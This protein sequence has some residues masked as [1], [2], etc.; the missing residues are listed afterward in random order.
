MSHENVEVS[1]RAFEDAWNNG[2]VDVLEE[3][4][5]DGFVDHDPLMGDQDAE[6]IKRTVAM[7]REAFPDLTMTIDDIFAAD[8]DK[9]V[10]R[11]TA[12]GTFQNEIMG[13]Q[14]NNNRATVSG[15]A[16]DRFEDGR[17][18][19]TWGQWNTLKFMQSIGAIPTEASAAV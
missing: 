6:G 18:A 2:N 13:I 1:R 5:A 7:Y 8:G 17:I 11:W 16:I 14:P 12:D 15:I 4:T 10:M 19:E 9:V 3:I